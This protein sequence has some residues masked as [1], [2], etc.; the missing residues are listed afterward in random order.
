MP[1]ERQTRDVPLARILFNLFSKLTP[2]TIVRSSV[3][4]ISPLGARVQLG[5]EPFELRQNEFPQRTAIE[6]E[7][8]PRT[9]NFADTYLSSYVGIN[10]VKKME[11]TAPKTKERDFYK[12][13]FGEAKVTARRRRRRRRTKIG[14][15]FTAKKYG[16][17]EKEKERRI[18]RDHPAL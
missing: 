12:S 13:H 14:R 17:E 18:G 8:A 2:F 3:R 11:K 15:R 5:I 9:A 6:K 4:S 1:Y 7:D 16:A 10:D